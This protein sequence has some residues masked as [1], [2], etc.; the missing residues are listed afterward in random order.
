MAE[1]PMNAVCACEI[2]YHFQE[3]PLTDHPVARACL[4]SAR[5]SVLEFLSSDGFV[6]CSLGKRA[7][8][9]C[10]ALPITQEEADA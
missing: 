4:W 7:V 5:P 3:P 8:A 2:T 10:P 6:A 1:I 9:F